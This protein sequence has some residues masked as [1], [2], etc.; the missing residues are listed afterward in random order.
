VSKTRIIDSVKR[1]DIESAGALLNEK[2]ELIG[3]TDQGGRNL[4]H[5]ACSASARKLKVADAVATR[6]ATLLLDR[7]IEIDVTVGRDACTALFFAVA[8]ARNPVLVKHLIE[9]GAKVTNAPGGGLFAAGWWEDIDILKM[10]LRAGA[11][12]DVVAGVTPFLACWCWKRL[13]AAKALAL[14]GANVNYQD[15]KGRTALHHG[16]EKDYPPAQLRWLVDHGASPDIADRDGVTPRAKA[17]RKRATKY[18]SVFG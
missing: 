9:R 10:L 3:V 18:H 6:M 1:L 15:R 4:L 16:L 11:P 2:P 17:S 8:R 12:I 13:D 5:I 14:A 7:G